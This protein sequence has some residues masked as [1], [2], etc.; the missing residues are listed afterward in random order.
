MQH[1]LK[2]IKMNIHMNVYTKPYS[3]T[4]SQSPYLL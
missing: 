4:R 3:N 2:T 1:R